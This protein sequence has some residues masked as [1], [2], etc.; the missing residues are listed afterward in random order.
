MVPEHEK[1][2]REATITDLYVGEWLIKGQR[3]TAVFFGTIAL[4]TIL[5]AG[6]SLW[7]LIIPTLL[8]YRASCRQYMIVILRSELERRRLESGV[9]VAVKD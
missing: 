9:Q 6:W 1:P 7:L 2:L 8:F 5:W 4:V 3:N